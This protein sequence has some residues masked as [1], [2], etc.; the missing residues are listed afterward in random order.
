M[1]RHNFFQHA[2]RPSRV[3]FAVSRAAAITL[4][5][6]IIAWIALSILFAPPQSSE[7]VANVE[8]K[9]ET[10]EAPAGPASASP[11]PDAQPA[12]EPASG[13][14]M[15]VHVAGAVNKPG[16]YELEPGARIVDA[17]EAA[18]GMDADAR[19]D[20]LNLASPVADGQQVLLPG[21]DTPAGPAPDSSPAAQP[22]GSGAA[23]PADSGDKIA[24]NQAD[25]ETLMQLPGIGPALAG[26]II[27][28]REAN[29]PFTSVEELDE[30]S[31]I[32]PVLMERLKDLVQVP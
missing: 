10:T 11:G 1:G 16:V 32:G 22:L 14:T 4:V 13:D 9:A 7:V 2:P 5:L 18:G 31:G 20:M 17:I 30:V 23:A 19:P 29:G 15:L 28:F 8:A 6:G 27:D 26:R 24:V 12:A 21:A 25:A 3:R